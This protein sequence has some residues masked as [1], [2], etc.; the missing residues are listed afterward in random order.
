MANPTAGPASSEGKSR[1]NWIPRGPQKGGQFSNATAYDS[2]PDDFS[3]VL[4]LVIDGGK[5]TPRPSQ[6]QL[7]NPFG[8][9]PTPCSALH[10]FNFYN[11]SGVGT[12]KVIAAANTGVQ[13]TTDNVTLL[14]AAGN[15]GRY[16]FQTVKNR[17]YF[18]NGSAT[19]SISKD[20]TA[21]GTF[22]WGVAAP[23]SAMTYTVNS[24]FYNTGTLAATNG[25]PSLVGTGTTWVTGSTWVGLPIFINNVQY[26]IAAVPST[27]TM[28]LTTNYQGVTAG[29]L[30]YK[31]QL[32]AM[33]WQAGSGFKYAFAYWNDASGH[34]SNISPI[35]TVNDGTPNNVGS[36]VT[37][38]PKAF[39]FPC[40][41]NSTKVVNCCPRCVVTLVMRAARVC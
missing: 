11:S 3:E 7:A 26:T 13:N 41:S 20:A 39:S 40:A 12:S 27:T 25:S 14:S 23:A 21:A 38:K 33:T 22:P 1:N 5:W 10:I 28:T 2:S 29:S 9:G 16:S 32:G 34:I 24:N 18:C 36:N 4:D 35:T 17:L 30:L 37:L 19:P 15:P 6:V 8:S 31:V